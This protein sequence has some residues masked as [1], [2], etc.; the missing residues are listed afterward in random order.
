MQNAT[1][2]LIASLSVVLMG[3]GIAGA[4]NAATRN[5]MVL[6]QKSDGFFMAITY[7]NGKENR[8]QCLAVNGQGWRN[9]KVSGTVG[10]KTVVIFYRDKNLWCTSRNFSY[11]PPITITAKNNVNFWLNYPH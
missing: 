11:S 3:I 8:G 2:K 1:K 6:T 7:H 9:S 4:A 5:I 10:D